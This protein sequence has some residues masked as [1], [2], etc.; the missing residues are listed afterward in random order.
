[1]IASLAI[2]RYNAIHR[3]PDAGCKVCAKREKDEAEQRKRQEILGEC[4]LI[5]DN[6]PTF[7]IKDA[8]VVNGS[9]VELSF[10]LEADTPMEHPDFDHVLI[11]YSEDSMLMDNVNTDFLKTNDIEYVLQNTI[12]IDG[13]KSG[14]KY[15]FNAT[16]WKGNLSGTHSQVFGIVVDAVPETPHLVSVNAMHDPPK[17]DIL[18]KVTDTRGSPVQRLKLYQSETVDFVE[19][20]LAQ[21][22][23]INEAQKIADCFLLTINDPHLAVPYFFKVSCVNAMGESE[24]SE[25]SQEIMLGFCDLMQ[26]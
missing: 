24:L 23:A 3:K 14:V 5:K 4:K 25:C 10:C 13:L 1:M 19:S 2:Y 22:V 21:D 12:F 8:C 18:L 15:Y 6:L 20:Y 17:I 11:N 9:A 26:I 16:A 7:K